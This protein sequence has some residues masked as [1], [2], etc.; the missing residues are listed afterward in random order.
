MLRARMPG[1]ACCATQAGCSFSGVC[2]WSGPTGEWFERSN[3]LARRW[4]KVP[5]THDCRGRVQGCITGIAGA[6][7]QLRNCQ[8]RRRA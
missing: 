5:V 4:P 1:W 7:T 3:L 2:F 6:L 8:R